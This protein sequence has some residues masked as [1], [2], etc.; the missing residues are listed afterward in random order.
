M[1]DKH[2]YDRCAQPPKKRPHPLQRYYAGCCAGAPPWE[3]TQ[4]V[5]LTFWNTA[6]GAVPAVLSSVTAPPVREEEQFVKVAFRAE[7]LP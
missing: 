6:C 2:A 3:E 1:S 5:A 4:P 7:V